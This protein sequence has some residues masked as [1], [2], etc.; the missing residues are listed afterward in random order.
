MEAVLLDMNGNMINGENIRIKVYPHRACSA[1]Y[2]VEAFGEK[3][4]GILNKL[5]LN[6]A[7]G[8][9]G[10]G[11]CADIDNKQN[12]NSFLNRVHNGMKGILVLPNERFELPELNVSAKFCG[13]VFYASGNDS[14]ENYH[15][16]MLYNGE[17]DYIDFVGEY[18]I[19][20]D[21]PGEA[22]VYTY[23]KSGFDGAEGAKRHLPF[24]K[25][26]RYGEGKLFLVSL[27]LDG[28]LKFN[29]NLDKFML[30]LIGN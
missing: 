30:D 29:P 16:Y 7:S 26:I 9:A 27:C 25:K 6:P 15:F 23:S 17:K 21:I 1:H 22:L 18:T 19:E 14:Y 13:G 3:A 20:T 24:V 2:A 4:K 5:G 8:E 10:C 11:M 28:R 12:L